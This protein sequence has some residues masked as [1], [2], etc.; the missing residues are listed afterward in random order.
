MAT[1]T[2]PKIHTFSYVFPPSLPTA[3]TF[4]LYVTSLTD[5]YLLW[6]GVL[7]PSATAISVPDPLREEEGSS[8]ADMMGLGT[9]AKLGRDWAMG[10]PGRGA[11]PAVGTQLLKGVGEDVALPLAQ[12]LARRFKKQVFLSVD[13]GEL[14]TGGQGGRV[15]LDVERQ[16]VGVLS[17]LEN[18]KSKAMGSVQ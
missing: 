12:R 2:T 10:M 18:S 16:L 6:L 13:V 4:G 5:T 8:G 17:E 11:I 9:D 7:P 3:P 15:M 1:S 14:G